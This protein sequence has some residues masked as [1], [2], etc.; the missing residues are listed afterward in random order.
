ML[1]SQG[2]RQRAHG[3]I[4]GSMA[5]PVAVGVVCHTNL[6][7]GF[8]RVVPRGKQNSR[9]PK[10]RKNLFRP[11]S[12]AWHFLPADGWSNPELTIQTQ[13]P[14]NQDRPWS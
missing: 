10:R 7:T 11:E 13:V 4:I 14:M 6:T 12:P 1:K 3:V 9:L 5:L 2:L 8:R